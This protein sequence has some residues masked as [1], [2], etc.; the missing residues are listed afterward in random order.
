MGLIQKFKDLFTKP[1]VSDQ[2]RI[3]RWKTEVDEADR[4][5][6]L[7]LKSR[8]QDKKAKEAT[9]MPISAPYKREGKGLT[10]E[11]FERAKQSKRQKNKTLSSNF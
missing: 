1:D 9:K 3:D 7:H 4:L 2:E 11:D 8:K 5:K 6:D 10:V